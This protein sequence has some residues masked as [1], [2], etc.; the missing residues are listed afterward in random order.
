M[1]RKGRNHIRKRWLGRLLLTTVLTTG[2]GFLI[3]LACFLA[4]YTD[5]TMDMSLLDIPTVSRPS[6]LYAYQ[7]E[8]RGSRRGELH[9]APCSDIGDRR[10]RIHVSYKN[11][12]PE[13]V[14]AFVA[15][16]D[17]RFWEHDGVD[18]L[19]TL[20]AGLQYLSGNA[21]FGGSTITQ[22]LI[23]NLTG[24]DDHS[25]DRKLKEIFK[26]LDLEQR[27]GKEEILEAYLNVINLAEGC[28]G[29]GAAAQRYFSKDVSELTLTECAALAA[30]TNNPT[31]FDPLTHPQ[32]NRTRRNIIL[33]EMAEQG[34]ITSEERDAAIA[35]ELSLHPSAKV[36][37]S[38]P[39]SWYV[40][41][42][43][44]DVIRDLQERLGYS[45]AAASGLVYGGGLCIETAMDE[46]LQAAVEDYY[47]DTGNFPMGDAGR[48]QS[49]VI[50]MDPQTGDI[51][52]VAGAIGSKTAHRIQNYATDTHRPAGSCI[53]P[54]TV[55]APALHKGILNWAT[56]FEDA[57]LC[58]KGGKPWPAN[59]D[60]TYR[61]KVSVGAAVAHSLNPVS[62]QILEQVGAEYAL[63]FAKERLGLE[64]LLEPTEGSARDMTLSSLALGQQSRGVTVRETVAAYGVFTDGVYHPPVSY[65]RVLDAGGRVLLENPARGGE[66]RVL[67]TEN[68]ALMTRLLME[69][70]E[71]GTAARA[72]TL[73]R[74]M[75]I[76]CAGKT[77]TTQN[78]CDRWFIGY[79]PRLLAG[80]WMGYDYPAEMKG[81]YGNPCVTVW[82]D[83]MTAC[84]KAYRGAP[85]KPAFDTPEGLVQL[86]FCPLSGKLAGPYCADPVYGHRTETGWFLRGLEPR[87]ACDVHSEPPITVIPEDREDPLRIPLLPE[88]L[89][90]EDD[91]VPK[92]PEDVHPKRRLFDFFERIPRPFWGKR[93]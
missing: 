17:K 6:V 55:Y 91:W 76:Q 48:P 86:E 65:H 57:P 10:V 82:D 69:V 59:A 70:T 88:D 25:V 22:Q 89:L 60:G 77:G 74:E 21:S 54:L 32:N 83:L 71:E 46:A 36:E 35:E 2:V 9:T 5:Q 63:S 80:V 47:G 7:P 50:M 87:E 42:V 29:V 1:M 26:A 23:K 12:P 34:Y 14:N 37:P 53:K 92:A 56:V 51:L 78:N 62:V 73:N 3:W 8:D 40:D 4:P 58:D 67:S 20:R 43:V 30:I 90:P 15:I 11:V 64:S 13:L 31:R 27:I 41:L 49:A 81:I 16:E 19:R 38:P 45:Y 28:Y 66:R 72:V 24:D 93:S 68:A 79:T 33:C 61:G 39:T 84:E 75:G 18:P 52:A 44:T 85:P